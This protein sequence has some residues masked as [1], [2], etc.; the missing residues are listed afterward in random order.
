[1]RKY[2]KESTLSVIAD[3]IAD[4]VVIR[5]DDYGTSRDERKK[6]D[7]RQHS[8]LRSVTLGALLGLNW[9]EETRSDRGREDAIINAAEF[10]LLCCWPEKEGEKVNGYDSIYNPLRAVSETWRLASECTRKGSLT[11]WCSRMIWRM[12]PDWRD[13]LDDVMA[14]PDQPEDWTPYTCPDDAAVTLDGWK[15]CGMADDMPAQDAGLLFL[16]WNL[17]VSDHAAG[18]EA[19]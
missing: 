3:A 14:Y 1:M 15:E 2:L 8:V 17:Y 13:F 12:F 6:P 18:K 4:T 7:M 10:T 5:Y 16:L 11:D 9:G 19:V